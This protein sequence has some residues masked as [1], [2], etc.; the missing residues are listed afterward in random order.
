MKTIRQNL[1]ESCMPKFELTLRRG[2]DN[3]QGKQIKERFPTQRKYKLQPRGDEN[4]QVLDRINDYAYKLDLSN[5]YGEEFDSRTNPFEEGGNDRNPT[6]KAKDNLHDTGGLM[7]R[8]KTKMVKQSLS[9]LSL[10]IKENL[11]QSE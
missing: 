8:P 2:V 5:A 4:F 7:T 9:D 11:E 10:G 1:L 3:M 6:N